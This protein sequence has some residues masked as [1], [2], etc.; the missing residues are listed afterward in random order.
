MDHPTLLAID[1]GNTN[2]HL[3]LWQGDQWRLSWRARTVADKMADEY[4]VLVRNFLESAEVRREA[5]EGVV[6]AC[7]VPRLTL[8]FE[9]L[10]Q[11][12]FKRAPLFVSSKVDIGLKIDID[13][14]EQAG[15][16]RLANAA[17]V[18]ALHGGGPCIVVDFGTATN[19]D[20]V[21]AD[22]RYIGGALAPGIAVAADALVSRAARLHKVELQPPPDAIG[23]NTIHAMQ[24]GIFWGYVG[25]IEGLVARIRHSL[26]APNA[27]VIGT[28]GLAP[29][30]A[31][32][33][34][35]IDRIEAELTLDGLRVIWALNQ[36]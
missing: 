25:L 20:V 11:R 23:R 32:H 26:G 10:V 31:Q 9:E 1:I 3:G 5:I 17:A 21:T 33:T 6:I 27:L 14:P 15:A 35:A 19:F 12:Y 18:V 34:R 16:D 13:Q 22:N 29:L 8:A 2:L 28:G 4:G 30:V 7:V 36:P 24:S